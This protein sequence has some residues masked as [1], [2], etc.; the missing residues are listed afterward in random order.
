LGKKNGASHTPEHP[1]VFKGKRGQPIPL[2]PAWFKREI[3]QGIK[4]R[5]A[6]P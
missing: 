1:W 6:T 5:N 3:G 4:G 2:N